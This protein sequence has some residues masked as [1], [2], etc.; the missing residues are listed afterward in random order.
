MVTTL[1]GVVKNE[2]GV[3]Q[4]SLDCH[5]YNKTDDE[6]HYGGEGG[7]FA[8]LITD[9]SG[10]Y[11]VDLEAWTAATNTGDIVF[12]STWDR[13]TEK[14]GIG[15]IKITA[16]QTNT[17]NIT[18]KEVEPEKAVAH[19]LRSRIADP[20]TTRANANKMITPVENRMTSLNKSSYPRMSVQ[21][22]NETSQS[23]GIGN[24]TTRKCMVTVR[25]GV[26]VWGKKRDY[27]PLVG[28]DDVTYEGPL[29]LAYLVRRVTDVIEGRFLATTLTKD[30][31]ISDFFESEEE[32][33]GSSEPEPFDQE[34]H[35]M[36][37]FIELQFYRFKTTN[38]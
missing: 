11:T 16:S 12:V 7:S 36:K 28:T 3:V 9:A 22:V 32:L 35:I 31:M 4:E 29:Q 38:G 15:R 27:Q 17:L 23:A 10:I 13:T 18:I 24:T 26:F 5:V 30:P 33:I 8:N 19:L 1:A 14:K 34:D 25:V 37:H 20:N 2:A 21:K 6:L